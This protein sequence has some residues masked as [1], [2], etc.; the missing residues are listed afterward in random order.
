MSCEFVG[1]RGKDCSQCVCL[2]Q[3]LGRGSEHLTHA[4]E[5]AL[6]EA[7]THWASCDGKEWENVSDCDAGDVN[8]A[9]LWQ[10][11]EHFLRTEAMHEEL[12]I[13]EGVP[14][15]CGWYGIGTYNPEPKETI[16]TIL[17]IGERYIHARTEI[18]DAYCDLKFFNIIMGHGGIGSSIRG[19]VV[20]AD[21]DKVFPWKVIFLEPQKIRPPTKRAPVKIIRF[22]KKFILGENEGERVWIDP[23]MTKLIKSYDTETF[24]MK[25]V[26]SDHGFPW[27]ATYVHPPDEKRNGGNH[28]IADLLVI[29]PTWKGPFGRQY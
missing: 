11:G 20:K 10:D 17:D 5:M 4:E 12:A 29:T 18:G 2:C 26:K 21:V 7:C 27:K 3:A 28:V 22:G 8:L 9:E 15:Q 13:A 23:K 6:Q 1:T 19:K 24:Q 14:V 16:L 25:L